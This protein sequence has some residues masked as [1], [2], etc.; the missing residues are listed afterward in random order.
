MAN[1]ARLIA[2]H[3]GDGVDHKGR[4]LSEIWALSPFWLE[5]THDYIQWLFPIPEAGRF[6]AFAP[7]LT[8]EV[9]AAFERDLLLRQHQQRSLDV[10]LNFFGLA[11]ESKA[12]SSQPTLSIQSHI[13]LKANGHNHLRIT[14]IIRSL[15]LC[16]Q[17]ELAQA[18]Q[19]AVI[20][21]GAKDGI[22]SETSVQ[23]WQD[24]I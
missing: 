2:F 23:F 15:A 18:F 19:Q 21:I 1:D 8:S 5:H 6:N 16:H 14:R 20:E 11:R 24:A 7:L 12:I 4:Y 17:L 10:M 22:V 9:Q 13:W 3:R